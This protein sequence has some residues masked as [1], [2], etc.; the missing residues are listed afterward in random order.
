MNTMEDALR[1]IIGMSSNAAEEAMKCI[2][3]IHAGSPVVQQRYNRV[4]ELALAD[5]T[6]EFSHEERALMA[7]FVNVPDGGD[8]RDFILHIR[9]TADERESLTAEAQDA[10][11]NMS[12]YARTKLLE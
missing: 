2:Q 8:T 10:G 6:V 5:R 12:Q 3:A 1:M 7:E 9:L 11:M 4:V